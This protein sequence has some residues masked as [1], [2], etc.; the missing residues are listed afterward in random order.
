MVHADNVECVHPSAYFRPLTGGY[1]EL[2][3]PKT[4]NFHLFKMYED[5]KSSV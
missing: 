4:K 1:P 3:L 5:S 2:L